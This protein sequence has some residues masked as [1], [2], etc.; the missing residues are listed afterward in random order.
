MIEQIKYVNEKMVLWK[1]V[2][3]LT[4]CNNSSSIILCYDL[5][6]VYTYNVHIPSVIFIDKKSWK[7]VFY[8]EILYKDFK[9]KKWPL[10]CK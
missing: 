6:M 7:C 1:M 10:L 8:Q 9:N 2:K 3:C 5:N 4:I